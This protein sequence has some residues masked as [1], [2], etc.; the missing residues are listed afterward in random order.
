MFHRFAHADHNRGGRRQTERARAGNHQ[1][2]NGVHQRDRPI[3]FHQPRGDKS[4]QRDAHDD[5]YEHRRRLICHARNRRFASLRLGQR[6]HHVAEQ[7]LAAELR[8]AVNHAAF[9]HQ[10]ARQHFA[11]RFFLFGVG[12]A[13]EV[14]LVRPAAAAFDNAVGGNA[15]AMVGADKVADLHLVDGQLFPFAIALHV[16]LGRRKFQQQAQAVQAG[17]FGAVFQKFAQRHKTNHHHARFKIHMRHAVRRMRAEKQ[18]IDGIQVNRH[19][20]DGN[21]YVHIRQPALD[22]RPR[23]FVKRHRQPKLHH[24]RQR[25]LPQRRNHPIVP[26]NHHACHADKE[27]NIDCQ[28]KP[29]SPAYMRGFFG[30]RQRVLHFLLRAV[31]SFLDDFGDVGGGGLAVVKHHLRLLAGEVHPS[32]FDKIFFVQHFLNARST[33]LTGHAFD[34]ET[35]FLLHDVF[36]R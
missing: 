32:R 35:D 20:A 14:A 22:A 16:D 21:E 8:G 9:G 26:T 4:Q 25:K 28:Q 24:A 12:F 23:A 2:G 30:L 5:R 19:R 27:R 11:A 17:F 10:R 7:G 6:V 15:F 29:Q 31:T 33:C 13:G 3:A 18:H 1:N 34:L 36:P